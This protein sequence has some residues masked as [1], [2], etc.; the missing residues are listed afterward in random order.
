MKVLVLNAGSSSLKI[1]LYELGNSLPDVPPQALWEAQIDWSVSVS[2]AS[3]EFTAKNSRGSVLKERL[4]ADSQGAVIE[5][6]LG[7][8]WGGPTQAI[9]GPSEITV[10]GQRVVHGGQEYRQPTLITP[11]VKLA[12]ARLAVFAPLHNR[13]DLE[14]IEA[15]ERVVGRIP[16]VAVFDTAFHS[17][18]DL[19]ASVYPGPYEWYERGIRRYGFH[20]VSHQ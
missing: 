17:R 3:A 1:C 2:S 9:A 15:V 14:T 7:A 4:Q 11:E 5:R 8:L 18:L 20:G 12:I 10:V 6:L 19:A 13:A 16:Q